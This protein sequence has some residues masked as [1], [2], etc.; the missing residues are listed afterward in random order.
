MKRVLAF[1][2]IN[3]TF[4]E[5]ANIFP[6]LTKIR[7]IGKAVLK[8][9]LEKLDL[10]EPLKIKKLD[11][12]TRELLEKELSLR[13]IED[14]RKNK[15]IQILDLQKA[16]GSNRGFRHSNKLKVRG[17]STKST[18]RKTKKTRVKK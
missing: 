10:R 12:L 11:S 9:V 1:K 15:L 14:K 7:G 2:S 4:N 3:R 5:D 6:E 8:E 13:I 17:Q 16:I 18:G